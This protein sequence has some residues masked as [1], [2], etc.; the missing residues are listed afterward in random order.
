MG[1]HGFVYNNKTTRLE[2]LAKYLILVYINFVSQKIKIY[3]VHSWAASLGIMTLQL[4]LISIKQ[5]FQ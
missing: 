4:Q 5:T 1:Q 2:T 3:H